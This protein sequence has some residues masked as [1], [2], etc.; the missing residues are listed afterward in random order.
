MANRTNRNR[1]AR[2]TRARTTRASAG[3]SGFNPAKLGNAPN[4][5]YLK[6]VVNA[7]TPLAPKGATVRVGYRANSVY[8]TAPSGINANLA[9]T[10]LSALPF[11][12]LVSVKARAGS[13]KP[14]RLTVTIPPNAATYYAGKA[15]VNPVT[16]V[17]ASATATA[18]TY[19]GSLG[20]K[21][22]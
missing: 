19:N 18:P 8:V 11:R 3:N 7:V 15:S 22:S 13:A 6:A 2:S 20:G 5:A 4:S 10:V 17:A 14:G 21:A 9:F 16:G 12:A 1:R